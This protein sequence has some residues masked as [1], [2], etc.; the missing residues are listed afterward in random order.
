MCDD[1][2][3]MLIISHDTIYCALIVMCP[4]N[5]CICELLIVGPARIERGCR[6]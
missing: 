1:H 5:T 2:W 4:I 6:W 3:E